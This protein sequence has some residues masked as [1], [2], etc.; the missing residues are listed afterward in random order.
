MLFYSGREAS[1]WVP[2]KN[3]ETEVCEIGCVVYSTWLSCVL[4]VKL[5]HLLDD[6]IVGLGILFH[7]STLFVLWI[8]HLDD[9][10]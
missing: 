3:Q 7:C 5:N 8:S 6:I 2:L 10:S 4:I 1:N 9:P